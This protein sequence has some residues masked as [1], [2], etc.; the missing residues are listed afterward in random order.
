MSQSGALEPPS[1]A[2]WCLSWAQVK[3]QADQRKHSLDN[4]GQQ[5][6]PLWADDAVVSFEIL[7]I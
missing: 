7:I 4:S 3:G 2:P 5:G 6:H 1:E